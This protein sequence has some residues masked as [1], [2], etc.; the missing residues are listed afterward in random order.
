MADSPPFDPFIFNL[1]QT[2]SFSAL[3]RVREIR[4]KPNISITRKAILF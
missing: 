1:S 4:T 3:G 2:M